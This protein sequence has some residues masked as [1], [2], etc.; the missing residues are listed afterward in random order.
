MSTMWQ[1]CLA[2]TD[3]FEMRSSGGHDYGVWVT[4]PPNYDPATAQA[5]VVYVLDGNWTGEYQLTLDAVV[6]EM[7]SR[8]SELKLRAVGPE[9]QLL[10]DC[11]AFL[12]AR[13]VNSLSSPSLR[14]SFAL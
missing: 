12:T 8:S 11:T 2:N 13:T 9:R 10:M 5:P 6:D 14:Q 3:Y 4:T 7:I 1:G